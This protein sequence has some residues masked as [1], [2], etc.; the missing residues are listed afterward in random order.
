MAH[1]L[2]NNITACVG[3]EQWRGLGPRVSQNVSLAEMC[4]EAWRRHR[5][6]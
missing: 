4:R 2:F 6:A 5:A 1:D 3:D